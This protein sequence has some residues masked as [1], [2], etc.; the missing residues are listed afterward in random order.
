M[1]PAQ[2]TI[3]RRTIRRES[4]QAAAILCAMLLVF[5]ATP[6]LNIRDHIYTSADFSKGSA[7]MSVGDP[8]RVQ[9]PVLG[10]P[11]LVNQPWLLY[12]RDLL[13]AG[14]FPLWNPFNGDGVPHFANYQSAV[15]SPFSLPW[16]VL[17]IAWAALIVPFVKLFMLGLFTF[18]FLKQRSLCQIPAL[19]GSTAFMFSGFAVFWLAYPITGVLVM[20][21]IGLFCI[22]RIFSALE[23]API[24]QFQLRQRPH[25]ASLAGFCLALCVGLLAGHPE[26]V[27]FTVLFMAAYVLF[28]LASVWRRA[29]IKTGL[30]RKLITV[31]GGLVAAGLLA[32]GL[33][34]VQTLPFVE[35][36]ANNAHG[37][38]VEIASVYLPTQF[39]ALSLFPNLLGN[40]VDPRSFNVLATFY[41]YNEVDA[42]Y[43][44]G[45]ALFLAFVGLVSLRR[46]PQRAFLSFLWI[47][48]IAW[49]VYVF[50]LFG[51]KPWF[52]V[53][54]GMGLAFFGR[55]MSISSF[56]IACLAALS[57]DH[58]LDSA[59]SDPLRR[60]RLILT[61]VAG[62]ALLTLAL[63]AAWV[64][65]D[66]TQYHIAKLSRI[67]VQIF[68]HGDS[69]MTHI[70]L[71]SLTSLL[72][73]GAIA[74][75]WNNRSPKMRMILSAL[76]VL[77]EF[78]QT[79]WLLRDYNPT[80][81]ND[82]FYPLTADMRTLQ[83]QTAGKNLLFLR[84]SLLRADV[85]MVYRLPNGA[86]YDSLD[87]G[88]YIQLASVMLGAKPPA[89]LTQ[90][91]NESGI[92][93]FGIDAVVTAN[94]K[95]Q[96]GLDDSEYTLLAKTNSYTLLAANYAIGRYHTV[97]GAQVAA[98][99]AQALQM[100]QTPGLDLSKVVILS[101]AAGESLSD[102]QGIHDE[103]N[104]I[105]VMTE[106]DDRVVLRIFGRELPGYMVLAK[107]FYPGWKATV[108]GQP[109]PVYRANY[110]FSAIPLQPG[111]N[112]IAFYY[113]PDSFKLG[114]TVTLASL[115]IGV[116]VLI[117]FWRR[118]AKLRLT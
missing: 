95:K 53:I 101:P 29:T 72:A 78:G 113:D 22:E 103:T 96:A 12:N 21:P 114:G 41:N 61:L 59:A 83:S 1:N 104:L 84:G 40:P 18:L 11:F 82:L 47:V 76:L 105:E 73:V 42:I 48:V 49:F 35:Y 94:Q 69:V 54:P 45:V 62:I 26:T 100:V 7:L 13:R 97:I 39:F 71:I 88:H 93:L 74:L 38:H 87:I 14:K 58:L 67:P 116:G 55:S 107:T 10:D 51:L 44:G 90:R 106:T 27:Y 79:G 98:N 4:V 17:P 80:V 81:P 9:N 6:L 3:V 30:R 102:L 50:N 52:N 85:N 33:T 99:D 46:N 37:Q 70:V 2:W 91:I 34:A 63:Y 5:F 68:A 115:L 8:S 66:G 77:L 112:L 111:D 36:L 15:L 19:F 64:L 24:E 117:F 31:S 118:A 16:Y 56:C 28:R 23:R 75:L 60:R 57:L 32:L 65:V 43:I 86:T 89:Y 20:L 109:A 92:R 110:A 25:I 108:N